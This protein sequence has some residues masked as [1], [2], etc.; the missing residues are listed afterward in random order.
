MSHLI[1]EYNEKYN[2]NK[3]TCPEGHY[4]T[5]WNKEDIKEY[6]ASTI[7]YTPV[8]FNIDEYYCISE[9]EHNGYMNRQREILEKEEKNI[10]NEPISGSTME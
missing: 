4:I 10:M 6:T 2:F 9:D 1:I 8:T 3:I 5:N 7:M